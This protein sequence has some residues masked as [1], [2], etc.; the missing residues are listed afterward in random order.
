MSYKFVSSFENNDKEDKTVSYYY[1]ICTFVNP[2]HGKYEVK[3]FIINSKNEFNDIKKYLLNEQQL[4]NL[5]NNTKKHKY[6]LFSVYNVDNINHPTLAD[7][8]QSNSNILSTSYN[9][10]GFAPFS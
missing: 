2:K 8:L 1:Q 6:K 7:I 10:S 3:K 4:N 5:I 9:Y